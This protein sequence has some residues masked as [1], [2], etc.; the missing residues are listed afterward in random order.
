MLSIQKI[1]KK[2]DKK[3]IKNISINIKPGDIV[4]FVGDNGAGKSTLIKCIFNEY[5]KDEG[6]VFYENESLYENNNLRHLCFF[7]DQSI[8]PKGVTLK[9]YCLLDAELAGIMKQEAEEK[10]DKL[11]SKFGLLEYKNKT[12]DKLS[13]GMQK[14][15]LLAICLVSKPKYFFLDEPTA[16]LDVHTRKEFLELIKLLS[17]KGIGI[18]ITSHIIDELQEIINKLCLISEGELVYDNYFDPKNDKIIDLYS[19]YSNKKIEIDYDSMIE[20]I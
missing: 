6:K 16:N 5:K 20:D 3:G 13:A 19:K 1:S 11:L 18:L 9:D 12:F 7:P 17:K 2:F 15:A 4:G 14:K 10:L 8:Y